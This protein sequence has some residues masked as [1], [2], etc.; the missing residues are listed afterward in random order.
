[1]SKSW[2][3]PC[4]TPRFLLT[5]R[6]KGLDKSPCQ[7]NISQLLS[8]NSSQALP[9]NLSII[10]Y[11]GSSL[12]MTWQSHFKHL[13]LQNSFCISNKHE[14]HLTN[15]GRWCSPLLGHPQSGKHSCTSPRHAIRPDLS[16]V[17]ILRTCGTSYLWRWMEDYN[18]PVGLPSC[19]QCIPATQ[20]SPHT[21][22][23]FHMWVVHWS[24]LQQLHSEVH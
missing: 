16:P 17:H 1:V 7:Y 15:Q 12:L 20:S 3:Y 8:P 5:P 23:L 9:T 11:T 13:E 18:R 21:A 2:V 19:C 14:Q 6:Y 24:L 22:H 4:V 10:F